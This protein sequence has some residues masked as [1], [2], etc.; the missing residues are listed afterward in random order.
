MGK[1]HE[2][3]KPSPRALARRQAMVDAATELFLEQGFERTSVSDIVARSK[4]SRSTLYEQFGNK[5]GLL[6]AMIEDMTANVWSLVGDDGDEGALTEEGLVRLGLRFTSAALDTRAINLFR[7]LA[8]ESH[9]LPEVAQFFYECG[10]A[11]VE[12]LLGRRFSA[13]WG[14]N[15]ALP[16]PER[17]AQ[18]F[19]GA[20]LGIFHNHCIMGL[21]GPCS[22]EAIEGHVRTCVRVFLRGVAPTAD[23]TPPPGGETGPATDPRDA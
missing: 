18:I 14:D 15:P 3:D 4:G 8:A 19:L 20:L 13:A 23:F 16:A 21:S 2:Q 9:H 17:L 7:I 22:P 12:T 6:R 1:E 5:E 10:P 11:K